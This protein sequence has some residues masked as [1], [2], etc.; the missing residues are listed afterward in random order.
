MYTGCWS[1][2]RFDSFFVLQISIVV[3]QLILLSEHAE[4]YQM[5]ALTDTFWLCKGRVLFILR[6]II[7]QDFFWIKNNHIFSGICNGCMIKCKDLIPNTPEFMVWYLKK[8]LIYDVMQICPYTSIWQYIG[9]YFV[10]ILL[11]LFIIAISIVI[12]FFNFKTVLKL[13]IMRTKGWCFNKG[14]KPNT[15]L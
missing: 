6:I 13:F 10:I 12:S 11:V 9:W 15:L 14:I 2:R 7:P 1:W 4:C 8:N 3:N 5:H